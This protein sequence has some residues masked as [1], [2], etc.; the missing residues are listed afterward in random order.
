MAEEYFVF[1]RIQAAGDAEGDEVLVV[2]VIVDELDIGHFLYIVSEVG[3]V[4]TEYKEGRGGPR[5]REV[6]YTARDRPLH[7][8]MVVS[9]VSGHVQV[10]RW[11]DDG[12]VRMF[13]PS[14][15]IYLSTRDIYFL[16]TTVGGSE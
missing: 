5:R 15:G 1:I 12:R 13:R 16:Q 9:T 14:Q 7:Y 8:F 11:Q 4:G 10:V 2:D 3:K 6:I